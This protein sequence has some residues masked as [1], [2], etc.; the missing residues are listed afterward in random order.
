[1]DELPQIAQMRI[2]PA[3]VG[4][5]AYPLADDV[6]QRIGFRHELSSFVAASTDWMIYRFYRDASGRWQ[7]AHVVPFLPGIPK[8]I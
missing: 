6:K 7:R 3:A 8:D 5:M 2:E 4:F 1:M